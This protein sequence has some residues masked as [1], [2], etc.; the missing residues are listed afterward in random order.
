VSETREPLESAETVLAEAVAHLQRILQLAGF[1][2][3]VSAT[4]QEHVITLNVTGDDGAALITKPSGA[5]TSAV[6]DALAWVV[7]RS[8]KTSSIEHTVVVDA[9][10][11]R[12]QRVEA[13]ASLAHS[14]GEKAQQGMSLDV[15]G[16]SNVDRRALHFHLNE[17]GKAQTQSQGMGLY[18]RLSIRKSDR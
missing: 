18:R 13:L 12:A 15:F 10:G 4:M 7:R 3:A 8:L 14:L 16:M 5:P 17:S 11:Y 6:L 1:D 9:M 2:L